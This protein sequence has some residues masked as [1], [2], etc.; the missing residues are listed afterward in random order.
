[1]ENWQIALMIVGGVGLIV[2]LATAIWLA[3]RPRYTSSSFDGRFTGHRVWVWRAA[4]GWELKS[5]TTGAPG[6]TPPIAPGSFDGQTL[7]ILY[8]R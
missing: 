5:D 6:H 2:A 8:R 1:M 4:T 3:R 7:R